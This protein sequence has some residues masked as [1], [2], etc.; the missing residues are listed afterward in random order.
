M[1]YLWVEKVCVHHSALDVVQVSVVLQR[2]LQQTSFLTQLCHMSPIV[3][4]E[5]LVAQDGIRN[6]QDIEQGEKG[7]NTSGWF[8]A[9]KCRLMLN[10][11]Y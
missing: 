10:A 7:F 8:A 9:G 5:H 4:G 3:V 2:P 1:L 11:K 6:L